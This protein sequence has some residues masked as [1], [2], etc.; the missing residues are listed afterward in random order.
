M[1][2]SIVSVCICVCGFVVCWLGLIEKRRGSIVA[3]GFDGDGGGVK[4]LA[5][6]AERPENGGLVNES[7]VVVVLYVGGGTGV[8]AVVVK[9]GGNR[10]RGFEWYGNGDDS[11]VRCRRLSVGA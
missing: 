1:C 11:R 6:Q 5:M 7:A 9:T 2:L 4:S 3:D 8:E 10:G